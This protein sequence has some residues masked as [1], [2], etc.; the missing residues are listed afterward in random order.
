MGSQDVCVY[1]VFGSWHSFEKHLRP[2]LETGEMFPRGRGGVRAWAA[3][4]VLRESVAQGNPA[5]VGIWWLAS[6]FTP[7]LLRLCP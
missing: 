4:G 6:R 1:G 5:P 3:S 2:F 7:W